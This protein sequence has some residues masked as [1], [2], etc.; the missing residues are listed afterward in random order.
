MNGNSLTFYTRNKTIDKV[1]VLCYLTIRLTRLQL[2]AITKFKTY[3]KEAFITQI[4]VTLQ[5]TYNSIVD[6][7]I[8]SYTLLQNLSILIQR[9][10]FILIRTVISFFIR[11]LVE[12]RNVLY[13]L[14][15]IER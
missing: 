1:F 10:A 9:K 11:Y 7:M 6:R 2:H 8:H 15:I 12:K 4:F 5:F 3:V 13:T 14:R